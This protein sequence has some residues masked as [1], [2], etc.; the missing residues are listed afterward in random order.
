MDATHQRGAFI[1]Q[2]PSAF[3]FVR[4]QRTHRRAPRGGGQIGLRDME[5]GHV[6]GGQI[7]PVAAEVLGDVLEMLDDLQGG[8]DGVGA[9]DAFGAGGAGDLQDQPAHRVG[10]ELAV[11]QEPPRTSCSGGPSGPAGSPR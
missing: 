3:G 11:G 4:D 9:A 5:P 10:G 8:A 2:F 7:D 6:L 1:Q